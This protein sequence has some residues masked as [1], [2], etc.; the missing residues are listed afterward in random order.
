[1]KTS[2][3]LIFI[4]SVNMLLYSQGSG[5]ALNFDGSNDY[6]YGHGA[7]LTS[8]SNNFTIEFWYNASTTI[9]IKP[10][11]NGL[12]DISGTTGN[13]QRY[14]VYPE[15]GGG[16]C[17]VAG[18]S[19]AGISAGTNAI[20]VYEHRACYMPCLLSY[21]GGLIQSG[22]NHV[23]VVYTNKQP[24]LY[25]NGVNAG[26]GLTSAQNNVFPSARLGGTAY[27]W[28]SG[29]IDEFRIWNTTRTQ[30]EIRTNMCRRLTG[31]ESGLVRYY[32]FDE[33]A[34]GVTAD[35]TGNQNGSLV[36]MNP[37]NDWITSAA[38]IG[39]ISS[40][41]YAGS[42]LSG[43]T[44]LTR[45]NPGGEDALTVSNITGTPKGLHIYGES[46]AP[47][48]IC[49]ADG[50]GG[51][52]RYFGVFVVNGT[53]AVG[54]PSY[55][56]TYDY[57]GNPYVNAMNEPNLD[58]AQRTSNQDI[59][60]N[61]W[62]N[63][64]ATL[65]MPG[66]FLTQGGLTGPNEFIL[67]SATTP[68][69][70]KLLSFEAVVNQSKV[71]LRWVT[72]TEIN[73]SHFTVERSVDGKVWHEVMITQGAGNSYQVKEYYEI[74]HQPVRGVS[75]YRLKQTDYDGQYSYSNMVS[76]KLVKN[77]GFSI[78][79]NPVQKGKNIQLRFDEVAEEKVVI[80]L[81]NTKGQELYTKTLQNM[82][83]KLVVDLPI[84]TELTSGL[85]FIAASTDNQIYSKKI[86]VKN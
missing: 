46:Q 42:G 17:G 16:S 30:G 50:V 68:L 48:V 67:T 58:M 2:F 7:D 19:G 13:G 22:W 26:T 52:D 8:I 23:A 15:H 4:I 71:D 25:V 63:L 80:V 86:M 24:R 18:N 39:S 9:T 44:T 70:V 41:T 28:Y 59:T 38:P 81:R 61:A 31:A 84:E 40:R 76:V 66:D 77:A 27:G 62:G 60:C 5:Y 10:E 69:P 79:P 36:N 49:G 34:T 35:E 54:T 37:A 20:Q 53:T 33:G 74:D 57:S 14:A 29:D 73:N 78:F 6:V 83:G 56:A 47:N 64:S 82:E 32:R 51:N 75:Y 43:A 55:T 3:F 1:M 72:S 45:V 11:Q 65:N 21:S 12:S 85:Y